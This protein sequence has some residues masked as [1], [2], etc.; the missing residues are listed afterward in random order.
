MSEG[1]L[2]RWTSPS[3]AAAR[4]GA[5]RTGGGSFQ[6]TPRSPVPRGATAAVP[7]TAEVFPETRGFGRE[8]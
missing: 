6:T 1:T 3:Q 2:S 8:T 4:G 7:N 5:F